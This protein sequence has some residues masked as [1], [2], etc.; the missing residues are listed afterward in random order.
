MNLAIEYDLRWIVIADRY[1]Y[2]STQSQLDGV[3]GN[4]HVRLVNAQSRMMED[5]KARYYKVVGL[6]MDVRQPKSSMTESEY[7]TYEKLIG[8][9]PK[10]ETIRKKLAEALL[11][12]TADEIK[13]E[14]LLLGELKRIV[15]NEERFLAERNELYSKLEYPPSLS[16]TAVYESSQ[17]LGQ[18][19][20]TLL[21]VDKNKKARRSLVGQGDGTSSPA[22]ANS[23]QGGT[24]PS[25][26]EQRASMAGSSLKKGGS[27]I[28]QRHLTPR[29]ESKYGVSR[30]ERLTGG[31][32][33]RS[34]RID[35]LTLAKSAAQAQKVQAALVQLQIPIKA[36]MPTAQVCA[37][38]E[39][40]V[41]AVHGLLDVRKLSE[42]VDNELRVLRAQREA[43]EK[44][45]RGEEI[46]T[47]AAEDKMDLDEEGDEDD[48][49]DEE[50]KHQ[51][52]NDEDDEDEES[53]GETSEVDAEEENAADNPETA[54]DSRVDDSEDEDEQEEE[55]HQGNDEQQD[56]QGEEDEEMQYASDGESRASLTQSVAPSTRSLKSSRQKRA[57]SVM[58]G[59]SDKSIKRQ[60][61]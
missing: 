23:G 51:D 29:E 16:S 18:L 33:F 24:N 61:K 6:M 8:F 5:F 48:E 45:E 47:P 36:V 40:L 43:R 49:K 15:T 11:S 20:Q 28:Q 37:Q 55:E 39:K 7:A 22:Q 46:E 13:E 60:R 57:A 3:V 50:D 14:E 52:P 34:G 9:D 30:H 1:D 25:S 42:K 17:G 31:V 44:R 38:Y 54:G 4:D 10:Q 19:L 12:R 26:R 58:S 21:A 53:R 59:M 27:G 56:E 41:H 2:A 35:K 32:S